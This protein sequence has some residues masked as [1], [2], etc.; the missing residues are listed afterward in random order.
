MLKI[1]VANH[2]IRYYLCRFWSKV[3]IIKF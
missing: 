3:E 2:N 1:H